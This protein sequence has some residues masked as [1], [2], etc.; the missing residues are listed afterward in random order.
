MKTNTMI[1]EFTNVIKEKPMKKQ[2]HFVRT[3]TLAM[4]MFLPMKDLQRD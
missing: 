1:S 2:L 4:V 3:L